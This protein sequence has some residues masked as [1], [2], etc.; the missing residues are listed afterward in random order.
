MAREVFVDTGAWLA[1]ADRGDKYH[2]AALGEFRR[3]AAE[4]AT[5]VTTNLVIA[6][7]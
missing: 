7:T 3:L 6:E 1:I 4:R 2:E 5:L